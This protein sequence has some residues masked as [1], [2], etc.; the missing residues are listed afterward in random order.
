M[1]PSTRSALRCR[2]GPEKTKPFSSTAPG[3]LRRKRTGGANLRPSD[4]GRSA[5][6][7]RAG[8]HLQKSS[9]DPNGRDCAVA[10]RAVAAASAQTTPNCP[11]R[12]SS[13]TGRGVSSLYCAH[14]RVAIKDSAEADEAD[15]TRKH[16]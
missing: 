8:E 14:N 10:L 5:R 4:T 11:R 6:D 9:P 3:S 1:S 13:L 16:E 12:V 7:M 15:E 2:R